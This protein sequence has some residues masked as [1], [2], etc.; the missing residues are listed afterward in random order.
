MLHRL[1]QNLRR[2]VFGSK[3]VP[4][5]GRA[6]KRAILYLTDRDDIHLL[7]FAPAELATVHEKINDLVA[8]LVLATPRP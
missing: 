7:R 5:A 3:A 2:K 1:L 4:A 6:Q 8:Q